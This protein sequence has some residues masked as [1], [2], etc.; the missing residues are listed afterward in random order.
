M[1]KAIDPDG[2]WGKELDYNFFVAT[3]DVMNRFSGN[4]CDRN[5]I[6]GDPL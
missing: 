2:K 6:N 4:E 3:K 1:D 5:S